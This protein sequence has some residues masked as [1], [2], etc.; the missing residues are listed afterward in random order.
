MVSLFYLLLINKGICSNPHIFVVT[1]II[2]I[3]G[4]AFTLDSIKDILIEFA[5]RGVKKWFLGSIY[6]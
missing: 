3:F 4:I 2:D 1:I 6:I 5:R